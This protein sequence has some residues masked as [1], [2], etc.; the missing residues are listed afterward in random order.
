MRYF[1]LVLGL[2]CHTETAADSFEWLESTWYPDADLS[3]LANSGL[4][5]DPSTKETLRSLFEQARSRKL[6]W[7][8]EGGIFFSSEGGRQTTSSAYSIRP[9]QQGFEILL[10]DQTTLDIWRFE[11][12]ICG[13]FVQLGVTL[14]SDPQ[15]RIIEC[16]SPMPPNE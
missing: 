16:Y 1:I 15:Q 9:K 11:R 2:V 6:E 8:F 13:R 7:K 10:E 14:L 3:V 12:G 5:H 4:A